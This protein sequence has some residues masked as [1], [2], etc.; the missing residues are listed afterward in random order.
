VPSVLG[1]GRY[2]GPAGLDIG[3]L[4]TFCFVW[5]DGFFSTH[6]PLEARIA[7]LSTGR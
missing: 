2:V 3:T 6:Q 4:A 1:V 7:A 5:V